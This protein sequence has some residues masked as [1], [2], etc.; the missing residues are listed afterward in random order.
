MHNIGG[1]VCV[2]HC[3]EWHCVCNSLTSGEQCVYFKIYGDTHAVRHSLGGQILCIA[4]SR[5]AV[6][7]CCTVYSA[8][9]C[10]LHSV[11]WHFV[12]KH[13]VEREFVCTAQRIGALYV[14][15]KG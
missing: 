10:A 3:L 2:L 6:F 13:I 7:M 5:V 12:F 1:T 11:E 15:C 9:V 4:R 8:N 14:Y